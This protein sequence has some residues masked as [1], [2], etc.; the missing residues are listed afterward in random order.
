[1]N[2]TSLQE[3][4]LLVVQV[5]GVDIVPLRWAQ[6]LQGTLKGLQVFSHLAQSILDFVGLI[7]NLHTAGKWVVA[8]CEGSLDGRRVSPGEVNKEVLIDVN[9]F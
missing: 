7:Q 8:N 5:H 2:L 4:R 6:F 3:N 9:V 1:M